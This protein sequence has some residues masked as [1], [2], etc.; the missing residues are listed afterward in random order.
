MFC[1]VGQP[2]PTEGPYANN[3][4]RRT[5]REKRLYE[6]FVVNYNYESGFKPEPYSYDDMLE[7]KGYKWPLSLKFLKAGGKELMERYEYIGI[8]D[9]DVQTSIEAVNHSLIMAHNLNAKIWQL[10]LSKESETRWDFLKNNPELAFSFTNF[11]EIMCPVYHTSLIPMMIEFW[12]MYEFKMGWGFDTTVCELAETPAMVIH[13]H[14]MYHPSREESTYDKAA[15]FEEM[16]QCINEAYPAY[17]KKHFDV[18]T[19][20]RDRQVVYSEVKKAI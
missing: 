9:D 1:S 16:R 10:S 17:C 4:W 12:E 7:E 14:E 11:A 5:D 20:L 6:T 8:W 13:S 2:L 18:D 19:V 3:H 15:A